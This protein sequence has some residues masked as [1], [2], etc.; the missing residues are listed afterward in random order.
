MS[1]L[2][3]GNPPAASAAVYHVSNAGSDRN[4]GRSPETPWRTIARVNAASLAPG[5]AVLLRRS[6]VWREQ[7]FPHSGSE[8]GAITYGAYG[9]G[10]KPLLLGS[11]EKNDP[12]DWKHQGGHIWATTEPAPEGKELLANPSFTDSA[13]GWHLHVE[14]G[15][16]ARGARDAEDHDSA[17]AGYRVHCTRAGKNGSHIQF[18]T[19]RFS[20]TR[21]MLYRLVYR[22]KCTVPFTLPRPRIMQARPPWADYCRTVGRA[23]TA[24]TDTWTTYTRFYRARV[25]ATDAGLRFFLG[26][27]LPDGATFRIDS[28]SLVAC[29]GS[30][31]LACDVGNL[32]FDGEA[33]CGVKVWNE[34]DLDA[35]G[36]YWYDEDRHVLELFSAES[37]AS[38][39]SD[40]ECAL[41]AHI[42]DQSR[43]SHVV[44]ENLALKYGAAHGIGGG[45]TH[46]II[47]R[48][49]DFAYIGGGDQRG[50]SGTVRFGNAIEFWGNAHDALVERCRLWEIYDAALT[51]QNNAPQVKQ[52]SITYRN[53]LIWNCEYSFEY[54]N[55]PT[56]SQAYDITFENNTCVNAGHGWGHTQRADPSGRHLCFYASPAAARDIRIRNNIFFEARKNAFYAPTWPKA[57]ID[58]LHI[59]NNCWYQAQG[60]MIRLAGG[61]YT[62]ARFPAYQG[63]TGKEANSIA[64]DPQLVDVAKRDFRLRAGSPCIDAAGDVG[65]DRD[66]AGN[67][68]PQAAAPDIGAYEIS[69]K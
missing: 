54:W 3:C 46:H 57:A 37:P 23:D 64:R 35:Q 39:Y 16:S 4:D 11:V 49:C 40:V 55:R 29:P 25:T 61:S 33:S 43:A 44:Y 26:D 47:V 9:A 7:L 24:V 17:P 2:L 59:D 41:R 12:G 21:G 31:V 8:A 15:A 36:E 53:N 65:A 6:D 10:D 18:Y 27:G 52:Y 1:A 22:A 19:D 20:V 50:G 28:L 45:S 67:P 48:D 38:F 5:D 34:T 32:I 14:Q 58:A 13:S 63:E 42:I 56:N 68:V 30:D 62:M 51:N 69:P 66:F 60:D